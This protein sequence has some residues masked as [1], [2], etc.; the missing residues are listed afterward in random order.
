MVE[1]KLSDD[2]IIES[3]ID[4]AIQ[5]NMSIESTK[6][7]NVMSMWMAKYWAEIKHH[8]S[9]WIKEQF[10]ERRHQ[11]VE[12]PD[13]QPRTVTCTDDLD[14]SVRED[15]LNV[16]DEEVIRFAA[17]LKAEHTESLVEREDDLKP[18]FTFA[19]G[20]RASNINPEQSSITTI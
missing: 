10:A 4:A 7:L 11:Q 9:S 20:N 16:L 17:R 14:E 2:Q 15:Q 1:A 5:A 13:S 8:S 6:K 19:T 18:E 12:I 3:I